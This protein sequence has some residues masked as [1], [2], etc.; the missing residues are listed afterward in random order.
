M[1]EEKIHREIKIL[2]TLY[3]GP[4]IVKLYDV[5]RDQVSNTPSLIFEH[6]PNIETKKLIM[7]M[8][9]FEIRLYTYK[10]L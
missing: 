6:I 10:I 7:M 5:V 9:D 1:R 8:T 3:G 2:Q 4:N